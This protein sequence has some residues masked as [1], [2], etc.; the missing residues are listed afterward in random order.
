[1]DQPVREPAAD[2]AAHAAAGSDEG[3]SADHEPRPTDEDENGFVYADGT[4]PRLAPRDERPKLLLK[5][6]LDEAA[7]ILAEGQSLRRCVQKGWLLK[8][9]DPSRWIKGW[10]RRYFRVVVHTRVELLNEDLSMRGAQQPRMDEVVT[11]AW[12]LY[13]EDELVTEPKETIDLFGRR[14]GSPEPSVERSFP[15]AFQV[16]HE[17]RRTYVLRP[18]PIDNETEDLDVLA[19]ESTRW[20][21]T[22]NAAVDSIGR[23]FIERFRRA[24]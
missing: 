5:I 16:A 14:A 18:C 17:R 1:M 20:T 13:Y 3:E 22:I 4:F 10:K 8:Q 7:F 2:A 11:A 15:S 21:H 6:G 12:L 24:A 19:D 9:S 23:L